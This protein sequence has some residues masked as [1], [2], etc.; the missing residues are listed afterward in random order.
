V[1]DRDVGDFICDGLVL[2]KMNLIC[3]S[4]LILMKVI[5]KYLDLSMKMMNTIDDDHV[6]CR[7]FTF[8]IFKILKELFFSFR[9]LRHCL[10]T[11]M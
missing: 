9:C 6:K 4:L 7:D 8:L 5:L 11:Q 3:L 1:F 2:M 10:R